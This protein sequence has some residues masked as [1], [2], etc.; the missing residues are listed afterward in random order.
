MDGATENKTEIWK[1]RETLSETYAELR[2]TIYLPAFLLQ[3]LNR[4]LLLQQKK[5]MVKLISAPDTNHNTDDR[6]AENWKF[7]TRLNDDMSD[8][9]EDTSLT[10]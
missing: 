3:K 2:L 5:D 4:L 8:S 6:G 7:G 9:D 1:L 10:Q